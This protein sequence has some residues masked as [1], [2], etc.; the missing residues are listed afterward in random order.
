MGYEG[1]E[2]G[3]RTACNTHL[4]TARVLFQEIC[5]IVNFSVHNNPTI[6][7]TK[8]RVKCSWG[9]EEEEETKGFE[10]IEKSIE[11]IKRY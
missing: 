10:K 3:V 7:F 4:F 9:R 8:S 1:D 11:T 2:M 5:H 6:R